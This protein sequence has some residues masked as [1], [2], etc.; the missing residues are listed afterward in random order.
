M[1]VKARAERAAK[2]RSSLITGGILIRRY[3]K[4]ADGLEKSPA[5]QTAM[6]EKRRGLGVAPVGTVWGFPTKTDAHHPM[7]KRPLVHVN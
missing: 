2:E 1:L 4:G 7:A 6:G 5:G 3:K